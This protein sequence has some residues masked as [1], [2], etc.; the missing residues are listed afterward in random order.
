MKRTD[1][2]RSGAEEQGS[3]GAG[4]KYKGQDFLLCSP[5]PPLPGCLLSSVLCLLACFEK[6]PIFGQEPNPLPE[7][8]VENI[9]QIRRG[10][11]ATE[12]RKLLGTP[13]RIARQILFRRHFEQW[14]YDNP[15]NAR[16]EI[17]STPGEEAQVKA[18]YLSARELRP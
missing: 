6:C 9:A 18:I 17:V 8:R 15:I 3:G 10:M 13:D 16:I 5:A 7:E 14:I 11:P 1:R 4:D 2:R 12:V